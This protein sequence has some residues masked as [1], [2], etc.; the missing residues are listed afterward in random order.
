MASQNAEVFALTYGSII[1]QLIT[2]FE[3]LEEVNKQLDTM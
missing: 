2:D 3:D 1:R